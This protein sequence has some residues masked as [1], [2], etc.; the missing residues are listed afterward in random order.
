MRHVDIWEKSTAG[1]ENSV[2]RSPEVGLCWHIGGT[3]KEMK[4]GEEGLASWITL[5][6]FQKQ[7]V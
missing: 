5:G 3:E 2:G 4:R 7:V 1:R 6:S